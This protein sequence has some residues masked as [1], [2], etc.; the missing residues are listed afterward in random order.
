MNT[1]DKKLRVLHLR[2][3]NFY[4]GPERQLH[5]HAKYA[6]ADNTNVIISSFSENNQTPEFI[7]TI[8]DDNLETH[9]FDVASAYDRSV[10]QKIKSYL[11]EN[12]IDILC[13]HDYRTHFYGKS[14]T[15]NI[16]TKW[17]AFSRGMTKENFKIKF[18]TFFE[19]YLLR[20]ADYLVAVSESQ[21][22]KLIAQSIAADKIQ[23]IHNAIDI[24]LVNNIE[25]TS[26]RKRF[27]FPDDSVLLI[28]GGRFSD[29]KGQIYFV[30]AA[31]LA[32][33]QNSK[34]RFVLFGD[35]PDVEKVKTYVNE[36]NLSNKIIC[37]GFE[38]NILGYLKD[39]DI[40]VNP[41]LSEGLPNIVLEAMAAQIPVIATN[42]GGLPEIIDSDSNGILVPPKTL[43]RWRL[44]L[45]N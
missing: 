3:S 43:M 16:D 33:E 15:K 35:G 10:I 2:A 27:N 13:T 24:S 5:Y 39:T 40:L 45:S 32:L 11:Q 1:T 4:G 38:K 12:S 36:N 23:T 18:F 19:K 31:K 20:K 8:A 14:A 17:V 9:V 37:P 42:V 41:S 21:K 22:Q 25:T 29:E 7:T 30:Q 6:K 44:L 34:L 28:S 26:L